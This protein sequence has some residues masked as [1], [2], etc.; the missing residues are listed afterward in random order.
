MHACPLQ[1]P[2][3]FCSLFSQNVNSMSFGHKWI[4]TL[5]SSWNSWVTGEKSLSLSEPQLSHLQNGTDNNTDLIRLLWGFSDV[6]HVKPLA[7]SLATSKCSIKEK[8][9][10][11]SLK[12]TTPRSCGFPELLKATLPSYALFPPPG[13]SSAS[14]LS[15]PIHPSRPCSGSIFYIKVLSSFSSPPSNQLSIPSSETYS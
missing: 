4:P 8:R 14:S 10:E 9:K 3:C 7:Q 11:K 15:T 6:K 13:M 1:I 5:T 2:T 12:L